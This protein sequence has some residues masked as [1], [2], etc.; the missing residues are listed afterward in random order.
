MVMRWLQGEPW[1][2]CVPPPP[3]AGDGGRAS[4]HDH[5]TPRTSSP[6]ASLVPAGG[7]SSASTHRS[8]A[9]TTPAAGEWVHPKGQG[10]HPHPLIYTQQRPHF[11]RR[12]PPGQARAR[13]RPPPLAPRPL[14]EAAMGKAPVRACLRAPD[15]ATARAATVGMP[16]PTHSPTLRR[17]QPGLWLP[18]PNAGGARPQTRARA[19]VGVGVAQQPTPP[20][21]LP[22][23]GP[24][25]SPSTSA[26]PSLRRRRAGHK[27]PGPSAAAAAA[28][29]CGQPTCGHPAAM[30][31]SARAS[32]HRHKHLLLLPV[33][34]VVAFGVRVYGP[35]VC[36]PG[37]WVLAA[38]ASRP[39]CGS[40]WLRWRCS[41]GGTG[42]RA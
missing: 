11:P 32:E 15:Q 31:P 35:G 21:P 29:T 20:Q 24:V 2:R 26:P 30:A 5:R 37:G 42:Q 36:C 27:A 13:I 38:A 3:P 9:G 10:G 14:R 1:E 39:T 6:R 4:H 25:S 12:R 19:G 17:L 33:G 23:T 34:S 8:R 22:P 16:Q 7:A 40:L 18:S 41:G 28:S